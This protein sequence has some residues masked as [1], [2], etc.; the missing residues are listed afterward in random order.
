MWPCNYGE[1]QWGAMS[2][3]SLKRTSISCGG[4]AGIG[5]ARGVVDSDPEAISVYVR[6]K[7]SGAV[8]I[9]PRDR[10]DVHLT[11]N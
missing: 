11:M 10:T 5:R 8:R 1:R 9:R 4:P 7:S 3:V 2:D 6:S